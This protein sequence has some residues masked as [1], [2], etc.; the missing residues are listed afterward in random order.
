MGRRVEQI[1]GCFA[2]VNEP[3]RARVVDIGP[4]SG[5]GEA[6][7]YSDSNATEKSAGSCYRASAVIERHGTIPAVLSSLV[8]KSA[9]EVGAENDQSGRREMTAF[10]K[11][12]GASAY[13]LAFELRS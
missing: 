3:G 8:L 12:C 4:E 1:P 9:V 7:R 5:D 13:M 10:G 11:A 6:W 2:Y